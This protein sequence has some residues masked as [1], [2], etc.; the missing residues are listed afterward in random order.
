MEKFKEGWYQ[1]LFKGLIDLAE[2]PSDPGLFF[3]GR[4]LV[5]ASISFCVIDLLK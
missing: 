3:L 2:N 4:L 5:A 1:F